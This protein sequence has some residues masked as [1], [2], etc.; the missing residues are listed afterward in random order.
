VDVPGLVV[1]KVAAEVEPSPVLK[2]PGAPM[3]TPENFDEQQQQQPAVEEAVTA[4]TVT[5]TAAA[6][7][8]LK[9]NGQAVT[10][11]ASGDADTSFETSAYQ[12]NNTFYDD[13]DDDDDEINKGPKRSLEEEIEQLDQS[14]HREDSNHVLSASATTTTPTPASAV[15]KRSRCGVCGTIIGS[16]FVAVGIVGVLFYILYFSGLEH[17]YLT[18]ARGHLTFLEPTRDFVAQQA[19]IVSNYLRK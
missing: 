6:P 10:L 7:P 18:E 14:F 9:L 4:A 5:S 3:A 8:T 16:V 15:Q 1:D 11:D 13:E 19:Q 2:A 17:P 12:P